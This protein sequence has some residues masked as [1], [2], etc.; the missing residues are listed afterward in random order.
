MTVLVLVLLSEWVSCN[1]DIVVADVNI[2]KVYWSLSALLI[3]F[4]SGSFLFDGV[5]HFLWC[6]FDQD[7]S[8]T[9]IN[10]IQLLLII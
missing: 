2:I 8:Q 10:H 7:N 6:L 9:G 5:L 3:W 4:V 1:T